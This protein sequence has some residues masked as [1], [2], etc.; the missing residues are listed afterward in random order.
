ML[1]QASVIIGVRNRIGLVYVDRFKEYVEKA[2]K[3]W[4]HSFKKFV[5]IK[6]SLHWTLGHVAELIAKN[7]GY[8][9][10]EVSENTVVLISLQTRPTLCS[11]SAIFREVW[12]IVN[13]QPCPYPLEALI[14]Y[15]RAFN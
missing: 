13:L 4:L 6:S 7:D 9:L 8:T 5:H 10:A 12:H 2:Y 1:D 11:K 15:I 14:P 3:H